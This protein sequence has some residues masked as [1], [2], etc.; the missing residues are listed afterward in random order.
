MFKQY[1]TQP[2]HLDG[3]AHQRSKGARGRGWH[4]VNQELEETEGRVI[5]RKAGWVT[6]GRVIDRKGRMGCEADGCWECSSLL[7]SL[8]DVC[9]SVP[10]A[11]FVN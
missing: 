11:D 10:E 8:L 3:M 9:L 6:E 5:D 2:P 1:L 4:A 7:L